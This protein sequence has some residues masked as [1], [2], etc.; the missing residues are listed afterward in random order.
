V[1]RTRHYPNGTTRRTRMHPDAELAQALES[2]GEFIINPPAQGL[3]WKGIVDG[4][5][6]RHS[7]RW[8][9]SKRAR[10]HYTRAHKERMVARST[11]SPAKRSDIALMATM[12]SIHT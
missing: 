12:A 3:R 5:E 7:E 1:I 4:T 9:P 10:Q 11:V 2:R 6:V 8:K